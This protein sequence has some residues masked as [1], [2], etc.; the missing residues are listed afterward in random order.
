MGQSSSNSKACI[1]FWV[2][3]LVLD[4][5]TKQIHSYGKISNSYLVLV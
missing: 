1:D 2:S 5:D 3:P 4:S